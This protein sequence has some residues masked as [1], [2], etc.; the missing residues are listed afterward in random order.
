ML[1]ATDAPPKAKKMQPFFRIKDGL[2]A[3]PL[4][5]GGATWGSA[6]H[7][8]VSTWPSFQLVH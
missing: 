7:A 8:S 2:Q 1:L 4:T 6:G 5:S 3:G